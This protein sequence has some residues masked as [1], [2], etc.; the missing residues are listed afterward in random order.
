MKWKIVCHHGWHN[1]VPWKRNFVILGIGF[2]IWFF[3]EDVN[4]N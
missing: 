1:D 4:Y 3:N 2:G